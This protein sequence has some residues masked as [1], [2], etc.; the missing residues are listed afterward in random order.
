MQRRHF[1]QSL[2]LTPTLPLL[3]QPRL[4]HAA[5]LVDR[6]FIFLW[7]RG[8]WDILLGLDPRDPEVFHPDQAA[9]TL[10][11][12]G[13]ET[14]PTGYQTPVETDQ[15]LL[16]PYIGDLALH[17]DKLAVVRGMSMET[18]GH[19]QGMRRFITGRPPIGLNARGSSLATVLAD[20]YGDTHPLNNL[21]FTVESYNDGLSLAS[22]GVQVS[23]SSDLL[24]LLAAEAGQLPEALRGL[25]EDFLTDQLANTKSDFRQR[26]RESQLAAQSLVEQGL[27]TAFDL[28]S[29]ELQDLKDRFELTNTTNMNDP[30]VRAALAAAAI[31]GGC[32]PMCFHAPCQWTRHPRQHL[33]H[34][35]RPLS[36]GRV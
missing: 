26:S 17:A 14:L 36:K 22:T 4:A 19:V 12:T 29:V 16:G 5:E 35:S 11:E 25:A 7:F 21:S 9:W 23:N 2:C 20:A 30:A 34:G 28:D 27:E 13:Y 33:E 18:L 32:E 6:H 8:G 15:M 31:T 3:C 1:L 24:R 10:T